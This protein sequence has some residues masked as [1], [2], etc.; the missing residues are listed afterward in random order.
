MTI[1][2][3]LSNPTAFGSGQTADSRSLFLD[4]FGGE[5]ITA[6]ETATITADKVQTRTL[7]GGAK[8]ARFPKTWKAT[9]AYHKRGQEMLGNE[10]ETS[11]ITITP[12][13]LLVAHTAVYDMDEMLSHFDIRG[14]FSN[15]LGRALARI[16]D[17]NNFRQ[18]VLSARM[19]S[20]GPFPGGNR[21]VDAA[22]APD[23]TT[24]VVDG[25]AWY[26]A[27]KLANKALYDNDVPEDVARFMGDD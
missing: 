6:F 8:S 9:A 3:E 20:D 18:M 5:V 13:E 14:P 23:V 10:I 21:V 2:A 22:L 27:I 17:Q 19:P 4:I 7:S 24:G 25:F 16:Y 15:E 26:D 12:D 11:E 1:G